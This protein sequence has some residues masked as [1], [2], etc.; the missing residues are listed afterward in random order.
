VLK[1]HGILQS[2]DAATLG[3]GAMTDARWKEF[4]DD[5]VAQGLYPKT[6]DYQKA[7]T[8]KFVD[9]KLGVAGQTP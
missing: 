1:S 6:L 8:L 7:Y 5:V 2:G 3:I 4:T 9:Q